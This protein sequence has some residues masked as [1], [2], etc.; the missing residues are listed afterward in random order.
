MPPANMNNTFFL[1]FLQ[2]LRPI[3]KILLYVIIFLIIL[4][5]GLI[6]SFFFAQPYIKQKLLTELNAKLKV[7][8]QVSAID[9]SVWR[10]FPEMTIVFD[11]VKIPDPLRKDSFLLTA[12]QMEFTFS[13]LDLRA[14]SLSIQSIRLSD[15]HFSFFSD[16]SG[17]NNVDIL[18][19][20]SSEPILQVWNIKK[21]ILHRVYWQSVSQKER[22][23]ISGLVRQAGMSIQFD[24]KD[25]YVSL[26]SSVFFSRFALRGQ[27]YPIG[28]T[29]DLNGEFQYVSTSEKYRIVFA[30]AD[31]GLLQT[32]FSGYL[33]TDFISLRGSA[34]GKSIA[35]LLHL[36]PDNQMAKVSPYRGDGRYELM[37]TVEGKL[38]NGHFPHIKAVGSIAEGTIYTPYFPDPLEDITLRFDADNQSC[39]GGQAE[40][41]EI[42]FRLQDHPFRAQFDLR[43][44][45]QPTIEIK[46]NGL[47]EMRLIQDF[48]PDTVLKDCTGKVF[49]DDLHLQFHTTP[50]GG[51]KLNKSGSGTARLLNVCFS[52]GKQK[53]SSING[54][55]IRQGEDI[56][57][58][59]LQAMIPGASVTFNGRVGNLPSFAYQ[60]DRA[61]TSSGQV[62]DVNGDLHISRIDMSELIDIYSSASQR[63][64]SRA[65]IQMKE[66]FQMNGNV[67]V[68]ID[69]FLYKKLEIGRIGMNILLKPGEFAMDSVRALL[70][71][72]K[73]SAKGSVQFYGENDAFVTLSSD[74]QG[75][76]L[77]KL[78]Y[79]TGDFGQNTLTHEHLSGLLDARIHTQFKLS[80]LQNVEWESVQSNVDLTIKQGVLRN[81][82]P[83]QSASKFIRLDELNT[84]YFSE[85][86]NKVIIQNSTITVPEMDIRSSAINLKLWGTHHFDNQIDYHL[87][88]NLNSLLADKFRR[89][90]T[91]GKEYIEE[92]G[93]SG[94]NLFLSLKG[95]LPDVQVQFDKKESANRLAAEFRKEKDVL[96]TLIRKE[97]QT[98]TPG[99][100]S[101]EKYFSLPDTP[102]ELEFEE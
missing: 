63:R 45:H 34:S 72:G 18:R 71:H 9:Y 6:L 75:F 43:N 41:R 61:R 21:V 16:I 67:A 102:T 46:A 1:S 20:T 24:S 57:V 22:L 94:V 55:L 5:S 73:L 82:S 100:E 74:I 32:N 50:D 65:K 48:F 99:V 101:E 37:L 29:V 19:Q 62:L 26:N 79:Q 38:G 89:N 4:A 36:F 52:V 12:R 78:F 69:E 2:R 31:M 70:F 58:R 8:V 66:V 59:Q 7:R 42:S 47:L 53:Y 56:L 15:A 28:K 10:H 60:L 11:G 81:F 90:R 77:S 88:V 23:A 30:R 64:E 3:G 97:K 17:R 98:I 76:Q 91:D 39:E 86:R 95:K 68:E 49:L 80:E 51:T 84:I 25:A 96:K 54:E 85:I 44:F 14:D 40:I 87:K 33:K 92:D 27:E 13:F 83:L 35:E 93:Y